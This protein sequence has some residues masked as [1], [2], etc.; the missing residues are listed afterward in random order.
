ME[1]EE[2][3]DEG[4]QELKLNPEWMEMKTQVK[5]RRRGFQRVKGRTL[6]QRI[7]AKHTRLLLGR[8]LLRHLSAKTPW[9]VSVF[10]HSSVMHNSRLEGGPRYG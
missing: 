4:T 3:C 5:G 2:E 8:F 1:E 7:T 10:S 9:R 6:L